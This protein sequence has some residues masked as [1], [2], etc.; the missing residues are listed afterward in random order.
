MESLGKSQVTVKDTL[1]SAK[2]VCVKVMADTN[3]AKE[4]FIMVSG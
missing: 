1:D 2:M 3:G 4:K